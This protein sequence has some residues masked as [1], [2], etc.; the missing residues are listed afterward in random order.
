MKTYAISEQLLNA[1]LGYLGKQPY[2]DVAPL[3]VQIGQQVKEAPP[4]P[5]AVV[6][7]G[8]EG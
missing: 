3:I 8:K 4:A 5:L 6:P 2:V 1:I 7:N